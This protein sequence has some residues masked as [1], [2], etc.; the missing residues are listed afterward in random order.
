MVDR[1]GVSIR[2]IAAVSLLG[3]LLGCRAG[4]FDVGALNPSSH[5]QG[6][7]TALIDRLP[8]TVSVHYEGQT[9]EAA[10][11][12]EQAQSYFRDGTDV[13]VAFTQF[14]VDI[15]LEE[16]DDREA[17]LVVW[18]LDPPQAVGV[19]PAT[20]ISSLRMTGV[21]P[22]FGLTPAEEQRLA[23]M[24]RLVPSV[25]TVYVPY[26]PLDIDLVQGL[27]AFERTAAENGMD[28]ILEPITSP[29]EAKNSAGNIPQQADGVFLFGDR[30]IGAARHDFYR[31]AIQRELPLSGPTI[32]SVSDGALYAYAFTSRSVADKMARMVE[33]IR[34]GV[35]VER[36][37]FEAPEFALAVNLNTARAIGLNLDAEVLDHASVVVR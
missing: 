6:I 8:E 5:G 11:L 18:T 20:G 7:L 33:Q 27:D 29:A 22:G 15:A 24:R 23:W 28:L 1:L 21:L 9:R 2:L 34:D 36:I 4:S 26:N 37:P 12:R 16:R 19:D 25:R 30:S 3:C 17:P 32:S 14:A 31:N 10:Q 35:P 13:V